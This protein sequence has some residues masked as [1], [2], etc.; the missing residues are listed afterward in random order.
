MNK[1]MDVTEAEARHARAQAK[2]A[3]ALAA[4]MAARAPK[5]AQPTALEVAAAE[6]AQAEA[7]LVEARAEARR[8]TFA[9]H[10]A[11]AL[12]LQAEFTA[13]LDKLAPVAAKLAALHPLI[14]GCASDAA[15][16]RAPGWAT[17]AP[18]LVDRATEAVKL[19]ADT[20]ATVK[21]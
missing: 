8:Q 15:C 1:T 10:V 18:A 20:R 5:P 21:D 9:G 13:A 6:A 12:A 14:A 17:N 3:E 7:A 2:H 19:V 16:F 4:D 11:E